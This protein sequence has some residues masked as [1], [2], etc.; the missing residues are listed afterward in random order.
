VHLDCSRA[1]EVI[2]FSKGPAA[3]FGWQER[4]K[5]V[6]GIHGVWFAFARISIWQ[7][8]LLLARCKSMEMC[9]RGWCARWRRVDSGQVGGGFSIRT[10]ESTK[11]DGGDVQSM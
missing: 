7:H 9:V 10:G 8:A 11:I 1:R 5:I 4:T 2:V 3:G 6:Y